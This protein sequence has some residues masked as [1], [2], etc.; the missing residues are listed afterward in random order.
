MSY[1]L[2][3]LIQFED[4][5]GVG[6]GMISKFNFHLTTSNHLFK[7]AS[8]LHRYSIHHLLLQSMYWIQNLSLHI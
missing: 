7:P 6:E 8:Q 4:E 5:G 2:F 3:P 1:I